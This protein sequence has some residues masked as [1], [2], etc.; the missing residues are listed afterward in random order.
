MMDDYIKEALQIVETQAE[1]FVYN[2]YSVT[3][4][5]DIDREWFLSECIKCVNKYRKEKILSN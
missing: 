2:M 4:N 1:M 5:L 3:D